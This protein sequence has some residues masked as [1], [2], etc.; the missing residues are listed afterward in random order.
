MYSGAGA[1]PLHMVFAVLTLVEFICYGVAFLQF[2]RLKWT[3]GAD[4][5]N[6]R[7]MNAPRL[8]CGR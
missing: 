5:A 7:D 1:N 6:T 3:G 2:G 8:S 4:G